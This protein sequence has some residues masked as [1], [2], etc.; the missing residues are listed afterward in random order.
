VAKSIETNNQNILI[1][2]PGSTGD[3][4]CFLPA[5]DAMRCSTP[6]KKIE[7]AVRGG[8]LEIAGRLPFVGRTWSLDRALFAELFS[9]S[10]KPSAEACQFFASYHEVFSWFGHNRPEVR[11]ALK[12]L[13]P[14]RVQ[15]FAFFGGQEDCHACG[16]YLCC[17]GVEELRCPSLV[18]GEKERQWA[19]TY[20]KRRG[21]QPSARVLVMHPGSGGKRK[22]WAAEGFVQLARWWRKE[23]KQEVLILLGPAEEAEVEQW[24]QV[25][26]VESRLSLLQAA[27][28][29]SR[30]SLY[31]GN[32]SGVSHLAG[33]VGA[34]GVVLF[35]PT[36]P[37]Q[38][39]PLGGALS[40]IQNVSYRAVL[41]DVSGISL[42]EI[43][44]EA[45]IATLVRQGN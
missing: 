40:V 38:W 32:D 1:L 31:L 13:A 3:W 12:S 36:R 34:R 10:P 26:V 27:S 42:A 7:V 11:A 15:S 5:L 45:V 41:P 37:Q 18:L 20:W 21:W 9:S 44:V 24:Q 23:K 17:V 43:P 4:L 6:G 19:D 2:F 35:G 28:L 14:G 25:G 29:L 8:L 39:R 33:A 16:Y 22:R 30:S